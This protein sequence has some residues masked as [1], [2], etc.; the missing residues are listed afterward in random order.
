MGAYGGRVVGVRRHLLVLE[1]DQPFSSSIRISSQLMLNALSQSVASRSPRRRGGGLG[2]HEGRMWSE[3]AGGRM[4]VARWCLAG[5]A[6]GRVRVQGLT[7]L[8]KQ[9]VAKGELDV[10]RENI[11]FFGTAHE[12]NIMVNSTRIPRVLGIDVWDLTRV[13]LEG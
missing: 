12:G 1:L 8:M 5:F 7:A 9:A 2:W 11:L 6:G 3:A 10:P 13:E 4:G